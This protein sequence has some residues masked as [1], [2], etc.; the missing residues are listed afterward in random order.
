MLPEALFAYANSVALLT[1]LLLAAGLLLRSRW[2]VDWVCGLA[3][4]V[5][6]ATVYLVLIGLH[7]DGAEGGFGSLA[8]VA[9]LFRTPELLLAG[10]VHFLAF[11]LVVGAMIVRQGLREGIARLLLLPLLPVTFLF[12]PIGFLLF[13]AIRA[14]RLAAREPG[15][16]GEAPR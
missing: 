6:L 14:L 8:G 5:L 12:G 13:Q 16:A 7:W 2:I 4:P 10:W 9:T 3:I 11:D 15:V 1:W